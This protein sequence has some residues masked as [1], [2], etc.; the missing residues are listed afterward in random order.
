MPE[1]ETRS[2]FEA[3]DPRLLVRWARR[4]AKSRTISFLVQWV[5][6]VIIVVVIGLLASLT[7]T[8]YQMRNM[9][10]F[11]LSVGFMGVTILALAWFSTSRWSGELIW[12]IT[13]WLYGEEGYA[14][15]YGEHDNQPTPLWLTML[16]GGLVMYH[17][18][19]ALLV[20][21]GY[22]H[23]KYMQPFSALYMVPFLAVMIVYQRLGFWAWIWPVLYGMHAVL[24]YLDRLPVAFPPE[25]QILNMVVPVFGYGLVA[26]LV[27]HAYSRFALY[28]LKTLARTGLRTEGEEST[29]DRPGNSGTEVG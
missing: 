6:I 26:I 4:Y 23:I 12:R 11:W 29:G 3:G 22:L 14:A 28:R 27:G 16:G 20:S 17:L 1:F 10:L 7:N 25:W 19:A 13:Q 18:V 5:F 15:C 2:S 9:G 24:V 8:A 21:F